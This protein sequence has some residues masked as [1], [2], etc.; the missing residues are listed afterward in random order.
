M[1]AS[2]TASY[3]SMATADLNLDGLS[4][5][6]LKDR[7][8]SSPAATAVG[9]VHALPNRAPSRSETATPHAAGTGLSSLS[10][11]D[12]NHDGFPDLIIANGDFNIRASSDTILMNEGN[13]PAVTGVLIASPEPS[14]YNQP[15][16]LTATLSPPSPASL[17]GTVTFS[18]D[19]V[20]VGSAALASNTASISVPG[21]FAVGTHVLTATWPGDS[22]FLAVTLSGTHTVVGLPSSTVLTATPNP[23]LVLQ[24]VMLSA[25]VSGASSTPSGSVTFYD[26][27]TILGSATLDSSSHASLITSSL[28]VG[29]HSLTAVYAG[30]TTYSTSTSAAVSETINAIPTSTTLTVSPTPAQAF[31]FFTVT[32]VVASSN[33]ITLSAQPCFPNCTVTFTIAGLPPNVPSS[34]TALVMANGTA[35]AKYA[36]A[37]GTYTFSAVFNGSTIFAASTATPIQQTVIPATTTISLSASPNP[38]SQNQTVNLAGTLTAPLS[39]ES[40]S[41]TMTYLDGTTPIGAA[42]FTGSPLA[43]STSATLP[44]SSLAPGTHTITVSYAGNTNFLA[45]TS[46]PITLTINPADFT[47]TLASPSIAIKTQHHLTTTLTLASINGFAD[48]LALTCANLP[49]YVTCTPTPNPAP[50]TANASTTVSLYLD[51]DSVLGYARTHPASRPGSPPTIPHQPGPHP[52]PY[53]FAGLAALLPPSRAPPSPPAAI[54]PH[55]RIDRPLRLRRNYLSL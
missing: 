31:Q 10:I 48:S 2:S 44:I 24:P 1:L 39:S 15:F 52:H 34:A 40:P 9:I 30:N 51:T 13:A 35:T 22:T 21:T 36:F 42:P 23:A 26:G 33:S 7:R 20:S 50:L 32:A 37:V 6:V 8:D 53:L 41:G 45:S 12:L 47:I 11:A 55:S 4:D 16:S 54:R 17:G 27:A 5:L 18:V 29:T 3:T 14:S 38:A 46:A 43:N 49:T 28:A 19:G 25:T